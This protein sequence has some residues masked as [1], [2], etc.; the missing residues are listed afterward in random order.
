MFRETV[1]VG[2][3]YI[4]DV[5]GIVLCF[6]VVVVIEGFVFRRVWFR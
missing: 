6:G 4:V 1:C 3:R 5:L 2:V